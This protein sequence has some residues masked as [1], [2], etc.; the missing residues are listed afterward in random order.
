[1]AFILLNILQNT[2]VSNNK[3]RFARRNLEI[4]KQGSRNKGVDRI[5]KMTSNS[6]M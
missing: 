3:P 6:F 2:E 4:R 5:D 1:L